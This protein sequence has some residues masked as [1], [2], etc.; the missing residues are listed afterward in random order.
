MALHLFVP[1]LQAWWVKEIASHITLYYKDF[2]YWKTIKATPLEVAQYAA[3]YATGVGS[4]LL[5][6]TLFVE[7][8]VA[9][10]WQLMVVNSGGIR[11]E[12]VRIRMNRYAAIALVIL[13]VPTFFFEIPFV[14]D[15]FA[16]AVLPFFIAGLSLVHFWSRRN[17]ASMVCL[18]II[19]LA[20]ILMPAVLIIILAIV[21]FVDSW[22]DFRRNRGQEV[23]LPLTESR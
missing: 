7:L 8:M 11:S 13:F 16:F 4:F 1:H 15:A 21:G 5:V 12:L 23:V 9:R 14:A 19:Y 20:L 18:T 22:V 10:Y 2:H 3:P 6:G 17:F